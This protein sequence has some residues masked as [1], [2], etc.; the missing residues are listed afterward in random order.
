MSQKSRAKEHIASK[1][2]SNKLKCESTR[3]NFASTHSNL[4]KNMGFSSLSVPEESLDSRL[5]KK[6]LQINVNDFRHLKYYHQAE[7]N[8]REP[9]SG[10]ALNSFFVDER[11]AS[12]SG[13]DDLHRKIIGKKKKSKI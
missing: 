6:Y 2:R 5:A 4:I 8:S 13:K 10:L 1:L 3:S 12:Q 7:S 11:N 9:K